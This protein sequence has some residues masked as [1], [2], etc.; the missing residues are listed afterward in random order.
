MRLA[1]RYASLANQAGGLTQRISFALGSGRHRSQQFG[2]GKP[3]R[4]I[5][6]VENH[7]HAVVNRSRQRVE[8]IVWCGLRCLPVAKGCRRRDVRYCRLGFIP[9]A[10]IILLA[11]EDLRKS[12]KTLAVAGSFAPDIINAWMTV[13][14]MMF[15]GS[16]PPS[17]T[18]ATG[19]ISLI[20]V[21]PRSASPL[22]TASATS[23]PGPRMN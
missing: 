20:R 7:W 3:H 21:T 16:S 9:L 4:E 12:R 17:S 15:D 23:E 10:S 6:F 14:G 19:N 1:H 2:A 8:S 11:S 5:C 18:P 13:G 22:A